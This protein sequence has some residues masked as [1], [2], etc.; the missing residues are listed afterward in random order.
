MG[1]NQRPIQAGLYDYNRRIELLLCTTAMRPI[2]KKTQN[3]CVPR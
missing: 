3:G 1:Y 2:V